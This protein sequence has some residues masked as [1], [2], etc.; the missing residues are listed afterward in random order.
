MSRIFDLQD[1]RHRQVQDLLPWHV[2][3]T[4]GPAETATVEKHL[5]ECEACREDLETERALRREVARLP[6]DVEHGWQ[7]M[8][9]KLEG[10]E[11]AVPLLR[12]RVPLGW[13]L[14]VQAA[15]LAV[16]VVGALTLLPSPTRTYTALS[17]ATAPAQGNIVVVFKPDAS[18]AALRS[19]LRQVDARLVDGP[20]TTDAYVL[21]VDAARRAEALAQL[22]ANGDVTLAEPIDGA[23][24]P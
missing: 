9:A 14:A 20:T 11:A 1:A 7:G 15:C 10:R 17:A 8:Q 6:L 18:E 5:A 19:A 3:G 2:N 23:P 24:R 4:L 22:R 13:A 16:V 12:R 21:R